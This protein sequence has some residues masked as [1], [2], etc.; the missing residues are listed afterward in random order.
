METYTVTRVDSCQNVITGYQHT[1]K[2]ESSEDAMD[3]W[4]D[5]YAGDVDDDGNAYACD[6]VNE[7]WD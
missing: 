3:L 1:F 6:V 4:D 7:D 5:Y 2:A